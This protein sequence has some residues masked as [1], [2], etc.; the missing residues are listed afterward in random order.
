MFFTPLAEQRKKLKYLAGFLAGRL[1][2]VNMQLLY[3]CNF[4]CRIC[5]FW[6]DGPTD[7]PRLSAAQVGVISDKLAEVSPQIVSIGGGEPLM[8][9]E[10]VEVAAQLGRHHFPVMITNGWFMD[11]A[12]A[13][14]LWRAGMY[15]V[16]VSIDYLD[17]ARHDS[18]RG[19]QGAWERGMAALESLHAERTRPWQRVHMISVIMDDNLDDLEPLIQRCRKMGISY[20]V[21]LYS[22]HRGHKA[23][24]A[25]APDISRR[26]LDLKARYP[27]FV[28]VR[29]YLARFSEAVRDGGIGP[30]LAGRALCNIDSQGDVGLC[31]DRVPESVGNILTDDLGVLLDRLAEQHRTNACRDCWTSCRGNIETLRSPRD[32]LGNLWDYHQMSRSIPV[33]GRF[34]A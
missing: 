4:R 2:H 22:D 11:R 18:Q 24:K 6:R 26:L 5:E 32:L 27:E 8:H 9:A 28:A 25:V 17:P 14:A 13:G 29:G 30:C 10:I 23:S 15:E 3:D 31:I 19:R 12:T 34:R 21:T 16:S 7:R 33:G 1:I 20:L